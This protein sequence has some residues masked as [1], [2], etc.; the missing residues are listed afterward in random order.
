MVI[1]VYNVVNRVNG[2]INVRKKLSMVVNW[3]KEVCGML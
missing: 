1:L 3:F 2:K